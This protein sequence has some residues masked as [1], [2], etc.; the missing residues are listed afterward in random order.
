MSGKLQAGY[1]KADDD[2]IHYV[3]KGSGIPVLLIHGAFSCGSDFLQTDFGAFLSQRYRVIAPDSLA[4]GGSD[5]PD[6]PTRYGARQRAIHL[7]AVLEALGLDRA[8][9]VGYSMGGWMASAL[10]ASYPE[11]LASLSIGG[12]DVLN[13]MYTPAAIW[14]LPEITYDILSTMVRDDRPEKL[15]WVGP[16]NEAGLAAAIEGMNDLAGLAEA[17]A[18]CPAPVSF[19][20]GREDLY[21]EAVVGYSSANGFPLFELPGDHISMLEQHGADAA[22]RIS[23]FIEASEH[24][25]RFEASQKR[26]KYKT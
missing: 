26:D 1:A 15:A 14:D 24:G 12:W 22:R 18:K 11:R 7:V 20:L 9:V 10:A 21:Y 2:R 16:E 23:D 25:T 4:H 17:V 5:A 13:G 8:H 6:D 3:E 19:W